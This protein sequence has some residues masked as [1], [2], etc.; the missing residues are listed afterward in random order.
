MAE[1]QWWNAI[2]HETKTLIMR[3]VHN[4]R[5]IQAENPKL[6]I[7]VPPEDSVEFHA[8]LKAWFQPE[9]KRKA[10][11][12]T[13][14]MGSS[15]KLEP[16]AQFEPVAQQRETSSMDTLLEA[17]EMVSSPNGNSG[18]EPPMKRVAREVEDLFEVQPHVGEMIAQVYKKCGVLQCKCHGCS[19]PWRA[20]LSPSDE[21]TRR[22]LHARCGSSTDLHATPP[23][24]LK[25]F[26]EGLPLSTALERLEDVVTTYRDENPQTVRRLPLYPESW[27]ADQVESALLVLHKQQGIAPCPCTGCLEDRRTM[28]PKTISDKVHELRQRYH[29]EYCEAQ[30][31]VTARDTVTVYNYDIPPR[32]FPWL[33]DNVYNFEELKDN[34]RRVFDEWKGANP[35]AAPYGT[36]LPPPLPIKPQ[37]P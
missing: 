5:I 26:A 27:C 11:E 1:E 6:G 32:I 14:V 2:S 7:Q 17:V 29:A 3:F 31:R 37:S 20:S 18:A 19:L 34:F 9:R 22:F 8:T 16:D 13:G 23:L 28:F 35:N 33:A 10:E 21:H 4:L 30:C 25:I 24:E 15:V 36:R 12:S